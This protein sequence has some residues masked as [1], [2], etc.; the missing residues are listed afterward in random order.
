MHIERTFKCFFK[1]HLGPIL[2]DLGLPKTESTS[3]QEA[4]LG[5]LDG[6]HIV[7]CTHFI[8]YKRK[9]FDWLSFTRAKKIWVEA[10]QHNLKSF[11]D[12]AWF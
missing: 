8:I 2:K 10:T 11:L 1:S 4:T 12:L 3:D 5:I 6:S 7:T 9:P